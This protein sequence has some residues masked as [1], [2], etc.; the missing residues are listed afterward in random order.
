MLNLRR[1]NGIS[2]SRVTW[3]R[4]EDGVIVARL[5]VSIKYAIFEKVLKSL[6][7]HSL[8]DFFP[9][10]LISLFTDGVVNDVFS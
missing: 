1:G 5:L 6:I 4:V 10:L 8:L 2:K 7:R 3:K 9:E